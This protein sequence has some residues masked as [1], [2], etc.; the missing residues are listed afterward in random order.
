MGWNP[1]ASA[2][3]GDEI[4]SGAAIPTRSER[5]LCWAARDA[6]FSCLDAN[7]IIDASKNPGAADAASKCPEATA[8]FEKDCAA[9]WVK[10]F[11]QWRVADYQK[12]KR[13]AQ[14]KA[15][16]AIEAPVT[17]TFAGGGNISGG[18]GGKAQASRDQM[19]DMLD[20]KRG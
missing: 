4:R 9:A 20:R 19:Q 15:E 6:Y 5:A 10:Y 18:G 8:E 1:F 17:S 11:K 13:I 3:R 16:G 7:S 12:N 14:L 2:T